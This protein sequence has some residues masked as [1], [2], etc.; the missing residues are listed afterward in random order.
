MNGQ[1]VI[2]GKENEI[3]REAIKA[4]QQVEISDYLLV[5][6]KEDLLQVI[7][8]EFQGFIVFAIN[9]DELAGWEEVF[10]KQLKNYYTVYFYNSLVVDDLSRFVGMDFDFIAVGEERLESFKKLINYL[11]ENYWKKIPVEMLNI[12]YCSLSNL[13]RKILFLFETSRT[14]QIKI[15]TLAEK[16]GVSPHEI[17]QEIKNTLG[18]R[19]S[20]L[21]KI[22]Y[23][24]YKYKHPEKY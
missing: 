20:D 14:Q 16:I 7:R 2:V 1:V 4:L 17:R 24:Y 3:L 21:K 23:N 15:T 18:L 9:L 11:A 13:L 19:Y 22:I 10:E 8:E 5:H 12:N 6:N